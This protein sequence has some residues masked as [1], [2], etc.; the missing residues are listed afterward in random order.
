MFVRVCGR[1][2]AISLFGRGSGRP[3]DTKA[4]CEQCHATH[5]PLDADERTC[6]LSSASTLRSPGSCP[7]RAR[8][9]G[10]AAGAATTAARLGG[11][12]F[13]LLLRAARAHT[14]PRCGCSNAPRI[15]C[16]VE[17]P[18]LD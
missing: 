18:V 7:A 3:R 4:S 1:V 17:V 8:T 12:P 15:V 6:W 5:A 14:P 13:L 10:L 2:S 11:V 9:D 16:I